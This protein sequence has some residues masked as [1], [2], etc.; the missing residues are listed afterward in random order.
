[1]K[2]LASCRFPGPAFAELTDVELLP[3][4]LPDGVGNVRRDVEGLAVVHEEVD[5]RTLA[6]LPAVRV[7][8]NYGVGYDGIDVAACAARGVAVTNTPGVLDASTADLA[9]AL[10][11]ASRRRLVEG[12]RLIRGGSWPSGIDRFVGDEVSGA[13][14][15]IVG[16]GRVGQALARRAR[17]FDMRVLYNKRTRLPAED[18][19]ALEIEYRTLDDALGEADIVSLHVSLDQTTRHLIDARRLARLRPG[20]CLINT[21][22]GAIIDQQALVELLVAGAI[23]AGLDV[24]EEEPRVPAEL[25]A[26]PNVVLAPHIGSATRQTREAM[27]RLLVDNLLAA[28]GGRALPTPVPVPA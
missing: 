5:E 15:A 22:R 14:L 8:A 6:L 2:V 18:E 23:T 21:A 28:A 20:A 24:F 4:R 11:L 16:L 19:R 17:A 26:L 25:L 3:A 13:T 9:F 1:V 7:V 12:D 10:I 27:T